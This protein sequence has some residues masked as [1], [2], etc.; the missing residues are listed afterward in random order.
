MSKSEKGFLQLSRLKLDQHCLEQVEW[1]DEYVELTADAK[2]KVEEVEAE[3][4]LNDAE[5]Y[6]R[7][8]KDPDKFIEGSV[9]EP[10]IKNA[11]LAHPRHVELVKKV[12]K[13]KHALDI[14]TGAVRTLEHRKRMLEL[15]VSLHGQQYFSVPKTEYTSEREQTKRSSRA[16]PKKRKKNK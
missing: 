5:L 15:M 14:C 7:C 1:M 13:A 11:V 9:T 2:Q 16:K 6:R 8:R 4:T 10:A 12:I 3:L